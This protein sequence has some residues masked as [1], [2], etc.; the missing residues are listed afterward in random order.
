MQ[1]NAIPREL[2]KVVTFKRGAETG[3]QRCENTWNN[4]KK[5]L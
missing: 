4:F 3:H 5:L 1:L 2:N